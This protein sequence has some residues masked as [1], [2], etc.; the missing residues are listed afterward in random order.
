MINQNFALA[1]I[2]EVEKKL[3][4]PIRIFSKELIVCLMGDVLPIPLL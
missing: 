3:R 1:E 2:N 4:S